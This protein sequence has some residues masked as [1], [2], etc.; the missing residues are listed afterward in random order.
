MAEYELKAV[1]ADGYNGSPIIPTGNPMIDGIGPAAWTERP[2]RPDLTAYGKTKIVPMRA[3]PGYSIAS[4]DPD[5]RGLP[6]IAADKQ[7]AGTVVDVWV[8]RSEPQVRYYE[9]Q[10]AGS[11]ARRLL[12]AGYVQWPNFGLWGNDRL[13]VKAITAAQFRDVPTIKANDQI[14]L[15]EEDK[16]YGYFMGGYRYADPS[17]L[18]SII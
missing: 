5:P 9:V 6:V 1:P 7:V 17:R 15:L 18:K 12:P 16:I 11:E 3:A 2:D 8:D 4:N 10:L 14:T 13:L